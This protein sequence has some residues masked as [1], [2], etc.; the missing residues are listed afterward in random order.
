MLSGIQTI[1]Y[2]NI[3]IIFTP[4]SQNTNTGSG[5]IEKYVLRY[6]KN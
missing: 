3:K 1:G 4:A 5:T 6:W 2:K